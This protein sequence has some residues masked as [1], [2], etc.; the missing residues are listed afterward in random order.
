MPVGK[1]W[2]VV[3]SV[4]ATGVSTAL[5]FR[6]DASQSTPSQQSQGDYLFRERVERRVA[7]DSVRANAPALPIPANRPER[8]KAWRI[9]TAQPASISE[10]LKSG[11][12]QPAF[13][14]S[15]N[16]VGALLPPVEGVVD[17]EAHDRAAERPES[18]FAESEKEGTLRHQIRD[19]DTLTKLA[20]QYLGASERYLEIFDQN[21]DILSTP[22]LLPIGMMLRIPPREPNRSTSPPVESP[23][24]GEPGSHDGPPS[25]PAQLEPALPIVPIEPPPDESPSGEPI[26]T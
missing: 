13:Q 5:F 7:A 3:V 25:E 10:G 8:A 16:P 26:A 21:R 6:K 12:G 20:A 2:M 14:K 23:P 18:T 15:L 9:S 22:D 1:K 4:M 11:D 24:V 17:E 19:G